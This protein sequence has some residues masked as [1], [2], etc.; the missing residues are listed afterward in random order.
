[1]A[2]GDPILEVLEVLPPG[3]SAAGLRFLTGGA[4]PAERVPVWLFDDTSV[5]YLDFLC[6]LSDKYAGGGLTL[7]LPWSATSATSGAVVW[8]AAIR[9][10]TDDAED[11]DTTAHSYD[12]NDASAVTAPSAVGELSYDTITFTDGADM[13][14]LAAGELCIVRVRRDPTNG[15]DNMSGDAELWALSGKET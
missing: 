8:G 5:E 14:S 4:T 6:R 9:R 10:L 7:T 13:D 1:M 3:S 11:F 15:S 2:S 12:F